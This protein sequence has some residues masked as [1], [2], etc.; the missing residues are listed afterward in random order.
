MKNSIVLSLIFTLLSLPIFSQKLDRDGFIVVPDEL[1]SYQKLS[2]MNELYDGRRRLESLKFTKD[3]PWIIYSDRS[4]NPVYDRPSGRAVGKPLDFMEPLLIKEIQGDW[5]LV[6]SRTLE[7][8]G[9]YSN[10]PVERGW[11]KASNTVLSRYAVLNEKSATKKAMALISLQE[12]QLETEDIPQNLQ[13][14]YNLYYDPAKRDFKG[15]SQKFI[16]RFILK[17]SGNTKLLTNTDK[18]NDNAVELKNNVAG[19]MANFHITEWDHRL[20]LEPAS[21]SRAVD[22]Y[23]GFDVPVFPTP[24]R[25]ERSYTTGNVRGSILR[26]RLSTKL[27]SPY[28]M[29]LPILENLGGRD[30]L[31]QVATVGRLN[32][33][34]SSKEKVGDLQEKV[35]ELTLMQKNIDIVF[36]VDGTSSMAPFYQAVAQSIKRIIKQNEYL[37][38]DANLRF[39]AIIY[40]DYADGSD[41]VQVMRLTSDI[42]KV[43]EWLVQVKCKSADKDLPEAQ[44][45]GLIEGVN[46][47]GFQQGYSNLIVLIGDAG[48]HFPDPKNKSLE[49]VV[50]VMD[51]YDMNLISFQVINGKDQSF[52]DFNTDS[53]DYIRE[54]ASHVK[55]TSDAGVVQ[56][57]KAQL[58]KHPSIENTYVLEFIGETGVEITEIYR[59][60]RF[61]YAQINTQMS[62]SILEENIKDAVSGYLS[63]LNKKVASINRMIEG[64]V[65]TT[66]DKTMQAKEYDATVVHYI[67]T[68]MDKNGKMTYNECVEFINSL[69]EFSF[70]GYTNMRFNGATEDCY[71]PV[72]YLSKTEFDDVLKTLSTLRRAFTK[73]QKRDAL[74]TALAEQAQ[75]MLGE[76]NDENIKNMTLN[77]IWKIVLNVPFDFSGK[78]GGLGD[79]RLYEIRNLNDGS[80]DRFLEDFE[81]KSSRFSLDNYRNRSFILSNQTYY[82]VP[83][84][85]FPGNG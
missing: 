21:N 61:T 17:E 7:T 83:L 42:R 53:Q 72:V 59:F 54:L 51:Q 48:N 34:E 8:N 23:N 81:N 31:K 11:I 37:G 2:F 65:Q 25:L 13:K 40:R 64:G 78:Y 63:S 1:T 18:L 45:N 35:K 39:G 50:D 14:N 16:I 49:K 41:A 3:D 77:E 10:K 9:R 12:G 55:M 57:Q 26:N 70:V 46:K 82:W 15:V 5:L 22:A 47:V 73:S 75:S 44:Y 84:R 24:D 30:D 56:N 76:A 33:D 85:D 79:T 28:I 38:L 67:C 27:Q 20:C 69:G 36:A 62:T 80:F 29:R 60:G 74:Y 66:P 52:A 58:V 4:D 71:E 19:W 43:E 68:E 32:E 6:Y